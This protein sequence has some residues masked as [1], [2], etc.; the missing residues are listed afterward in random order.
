VQTLAD[1]LKGN[2]HMQTT[3]TLVSTT[4]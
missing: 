1:N 2:S 3:G 4:A